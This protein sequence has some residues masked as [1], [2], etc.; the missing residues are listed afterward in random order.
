MDSVEGARA[1]AAARARPGGPRRDRLA[2]RTGPASIRPGRRGRWPQ[3]AE[4][5]L[6]VV[7]VVHP[8][9]ARL[10]RWRRA[11]RRG[12]RRGARR[13]PTAAEAM[14]P[15][16]D[17]GAG[18]QRRLHAD[19]RRLGA[20]RRD[21]GAARDL[22][23]RRSPAGRPR[24][25]RARTRSRPS[26]LAT[27][28]SVTSAPAGSSSMPGPRS[29]A[30]TWPRTSPATA[31]CPTSAARS[32]AGSTTTTGSWRTCR[33]RRMPE[34]GQL[35]SVVPEPHLPGRQPRRHADRS[36]RTA[37]VVDRWPVDARGRNG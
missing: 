31:S 30:R 21:R 34:I 9:R 35:V 15:R 2:A 4:L 12:R 14:A 1:L 22:R 11:A 23:V 26:S 24:G 17:R 28:V 27:V 33:R 13:W 5:G 3:A 6:D 16:R 29:W 32:C 36:C 10:R 37:V 25:G 7:G 20:R 19:R 18:H 8:W